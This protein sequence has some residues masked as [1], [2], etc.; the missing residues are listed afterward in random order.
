M[1][2]LEKQTMVL[3]SGDLG[4]LSSCEFA[5]LRRVDEVRG[6][7]E[8]LKAAPDSMLERTATLGDLHEQQVLAE[9]EAELGAENVVKLER[10][11][12]TRAALQ[13]AAAETIAAASTAKL[14]FQGTIFA[15]DP[16]ANRA[17]VGF[18]DFLIR[19]HD[20]S[21]Q[22]ADTKLARRAKQTAA[23]QLAAYA[24]FYAAAG[25]KIS[26]TASIILGT[27]ERAELFVPELIPGFLMQYQRAWQLIDQR[28]SESALV[29][30]IEWGDDRFLACGNCEYCAIEITEHD[31]LLQIASMRG[32]TRLKLHAAGIRSVTDLAQAEIIPSDIPQKTFEKLRHQ[33]QLQLRSATQEKLAF[34]LLTE[35]T[36]RFLP[37]PDPGDIFFDFEGDPLAE[38]SNG[39]STIWGIDYLFGWVDVQED[40]TA[41]WAHSLA[42]ERA[43]FVEFLAFI[44]ERLAQFPNMHIYHYAI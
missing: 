30:V 38:F 18:S 23:L 12:I 4:L 13:D 24:Y 20:G 7:S 43:A 14:I 35:Q 21:Y 44:K 22:V 16:A 32:T 42:E 39:A 1:F 2:L 8:R 3:S 31:D 36:I 37:S 6:R 29:P 28:D 11:K 17:F 40:Y 33:A 34:E 10:P 27:K 25:M 19:E 15:E 41:L 26:D 9:F 5:F